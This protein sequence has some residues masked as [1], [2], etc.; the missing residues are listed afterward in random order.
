MGSVIDTTITGYQ[1]A[2]RQ[3][4]R[5]AE[6]Y[7]VRQWQPSEDALMGYVTWLGRSQPRCPLGVA[8]K[9]VAHYLCAINWAHS[10]QGFDSQTSDRPRLDKVLAGYLRVRGD[11]AQQ[12]SPLTGAIMLLLS[13]CVR[14]DVLEDVVCWAVWCV[15][16][17]A[18]MRLGELLPPPAREQLVWHQLQQD[19]QASDHYTIFLRQSKTDVARKGAVANLFAYPEHAVGAHCPVRALA[20]ARAL[21]RRAFGGCVD[22]ADWVVFSLGKDRVL[23]KPRAISILKGWIAVVN[24]QHSMELCVGDFSGHSARRGGATDL[25][26]AGTSADV[27]ES[28]GRWAPGSKAFKGYVTTPVDVLRSAATAF[29]AS[30]TL[31]ARRQLQAAASSAEL[32]QARGVAS[33]RG[34]DVASEHGARR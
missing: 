27:M 29:S 25:A 7:K 26:L 1:R 9:T 8:V 28:L 18:V 6:L 2:F 21:Q 24:E 31:L 34:R 15:A 20:A 19:K 13:K 33:A 14:A 12:K 30:S 4:Q 5:F 10:M 23:K 3:W 16:R 17:A 11:D 32:R 22:S